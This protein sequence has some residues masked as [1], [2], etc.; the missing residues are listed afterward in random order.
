[1]I[2]FFVAAFGG[3]ATKNEEGVMGH[4]QFD[5][6]RKFR[7][8]RSFDKQQWLDATRSVYYHQKYGVTRLAKHAS[9][10]EQYPKDTEFTVRFSPPRGA[11]ELLWFPEGEERHL[12]FINLELEVL[13]REKVIEEIS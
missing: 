5:R 2:L 10:V 1:M 3:V 9:A 12:P 11:V 7:V 8:R 6:P 13:I 4:T